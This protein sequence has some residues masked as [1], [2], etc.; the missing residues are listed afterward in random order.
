MFEAGALPVG[1]RDQLIVKC[2]GGKFGLGLISLE[3]CAKFLAATP[4]TK[5]FLYS[6]TEDL[7]E[8]TTTLVA[9]FPGRINYSTLSDPLSHEAILGEFMRSRVYLGMSRSDGL[10]T[11]FLEA[12]A[13]GAYPIQTN[14]SCAGEIIDLGAIGSIVMPDFNLVFELLMNI[15]SDEELLEKAS[16]QNFKVARDFFEYSKI[17]DT[18]LSFYN[19]AQF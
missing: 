15:Y 4:N 12:I 1:Q 13:T 8:A 17:Q 7:L 14:T 3:I 19:L 18:A 5:V 6:V 11:S 16:K 2:Y 10:S 9:N